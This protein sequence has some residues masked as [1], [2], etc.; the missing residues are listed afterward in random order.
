MK[1]RRKVQ[2]KSS[3]GKHI[4]QSTICMIYFDWISI[5]KSVF[6]FNFSSLYENFR[7]YYYQYSIWTE[8]TSKKKVYR[9][10][11]SIRCFMCVFFCI[12][13]IMQ[14]LATWNTKKKCGNA[15]HFIECYGVQCSVKFIPNNLFISSRCFKQ[16][17]SWDLNHSNTIPFQM[18]NWLNIL[19]ESTY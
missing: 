19:A 7:Y 12:S 18:N 8:N 6:P 4:L 10:Q 9:R 11:C 13:I 3:I 2:M 1:F 16:T 14:Q 15:D 5:K 17:N